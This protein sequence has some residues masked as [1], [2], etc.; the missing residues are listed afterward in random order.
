MA[1]YALKLQNINKWGNQ[2]LFFFSKITYDTI[3][4]KSTLTYDAV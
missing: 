3:N 2:C 1:S 4:N